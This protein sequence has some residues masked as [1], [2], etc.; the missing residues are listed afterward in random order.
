MSE[1][2]SLKFANADSAKVSQVA[3]PLQKNA[4]EMQM[5]LKEYRMLQDSIQSNQ[6]LKG[7]CSDVFERST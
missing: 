3:T 7:L 1:L 4:L 5:P 6:Y 2:N